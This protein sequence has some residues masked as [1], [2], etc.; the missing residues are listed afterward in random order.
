LSEL[1]N[2]GVLVELTELQLEFHLIVML[3]VFT[4]AP[5]GNVINQHGLSCLK[6]LLLL[7]KLRKDGP[8]KVL[9]LPRDLKGP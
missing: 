6:V 5:Q 7:V 9:A 3:L 2:Q 8:L 4:R 1:S